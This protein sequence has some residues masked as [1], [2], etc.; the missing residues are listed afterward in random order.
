MLKLYYL[1]IAML[2]GLIPTLGVR[3]FL[4][5]GVDDSK[6]GQTVSCSAS[7]QRAEQLE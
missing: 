7:P 3:N 1:S 2:I 5:R 4:M 6:N